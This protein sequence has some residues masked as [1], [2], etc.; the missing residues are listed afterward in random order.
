MS[1]SR[2]YSRLV[3]LTASPC[4]VGHEWEYNQDLG[5]RW[6]ESF[7]L[8]SRLFPPGNL[9]APAPEPADKASVLLVGH[10]DEIGFVVKGVEDNG[11]LAITYG[12]PTTG[13]PSRRM[14]L[15]I[16]GHPAL[17]L[18][19]SGA[20][21]GVF[22]TLT[23]HVVR[24]DQQDKTPIS[25]HDFRVDVGLDSRQAATR[26]GIGPGTAVVWNT[27]PRRI[28]PHRVYGKAMDNRA[29]LVI[30]EEALERL[31]LGRDAGAPSSAAR[32]PVAVSTALEESE[33]LGAWALGIGLSG[34]TEQA[35]H[36]GPVDCAI[37][38]DIG[39]SSDYPEVSPLDI[40]G[41]LG[42]GPVLVVKDNH[43][44]YD[45]RLIRAM[46]ACAADAG[47]AVQRGVYGID[48]GY[49]SDGL[50]LIAAGIP[51]VLLAFPGSYTHSPFE[52][53]DLRDLDACAELI[54]RFLAG[55]DRYL[56]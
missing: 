10:S 30:I 48:G 40:P 50:R 2:I 33:A 38:I 47:I 56:S 23:G 43:V 29:A 6:R 53:V 15:H 39:L 21:P 22:T 20:I 14:H 35:R 11:L 13:I 28:G 36:T 18:A 4:P 7:G 27:P 26:A 51:T 3:D 1:D 42:S 32:R 24:H 5:R 49:T 8:D 44:H 46:E 54:A 25:F 45:L 41:R 55:A 9:I 19:E 16:A 34:E 37:V 12:P 17:V 52:M 31:G